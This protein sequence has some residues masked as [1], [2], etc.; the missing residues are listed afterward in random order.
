M[1]EELRKSKEEYQ[2]I[3]DAIDGYIYI[4]SRDYRIQFMNEGLSKL[5]GCREPGDFC[6]KVLKN[7][8]SVCTDCQSDAVFE[9]KTVRKEWFSPKEGRWY[10]MVDTP[11]FHA[12]GSISRQVLGTDITDRKLAEEQLRQKKQ[13]LEA[14]NNSLEQRVEEEVAKN[15]EKDH[16]LIQ[17]NRQAALGETLDHIAH[18]WKQPINAISLIIQDMGETYE[19]GELTKEYVYETVGKILDLVEHMAQ[20]IS[21]FRDFYRPEKVKSTFRIKESI[22]KALIFVEPALKFHSIAVELDADPEL[23]AIGY[24][25][26]YAQV[27]LNIL[28]NARDTFNERGVENPVVKVKAYA[29]DKKAVVTITDNAGGIPTQLSI[30]SLTLFYYQESSG[31]T[32]VGLYMSKK[33]IE[34]NMGGSL[35]VGNVNCGAQFRIELDMLTGL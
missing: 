15:R 34:K 33:I 24:P 22:D 27:L 31:G 10:Y 35:S 6:F 11:I 2:A 17:Q 5:S 19:N 7:R 30:K 21:V 32:G 9:G 20:T 3:V 25:K 23:S 16:L 26:E 29:E 1:E 8:D 18:Q 12:D 4:A 28:T 14:L 13:Q